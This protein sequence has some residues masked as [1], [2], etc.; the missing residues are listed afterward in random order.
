MSNERVFIHAHRIAHTYFSILPPPCL[1]THNYNLL[2][3]LLLSA[4]Y[5]APCSLRA[6]LSMPLMGV[7]HAELPSE[8]ARAKAW[9]SSSAPA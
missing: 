5:A 6:A 3:T 9:Q 7:S 2:H 4:S 8:C 1:S